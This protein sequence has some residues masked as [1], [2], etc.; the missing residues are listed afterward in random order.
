MKAPLSELAVASHGPLQKAFRRVK[1]D[2]SRKVVAVKATDHFR[3]GG[4][5]RRQR[6][7]TSHNIHAHFV[8]DKGQIFLA[9]PIDKNGEEF[10]PPIYSEVKH[11][12]VTGWVLSYKL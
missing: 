6:V 4:L 1:L 3:M 5:S 10:T 11:D 2:G 9:S 8:R 12:Q 7:V